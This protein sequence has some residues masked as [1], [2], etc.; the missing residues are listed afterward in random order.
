M[1]AL[2]WARFIASVVAAPE[3]AEF[4]GVDPVQ[5]RLHESLLR[6]VAL[7]STRALEKCS[8]QF[9]IEVARLTNERDALKAEIR[10]LSS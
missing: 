7:D 9:L 5:R 6:D 1:W 8:Q 4:L 10:R 3:P 2:G